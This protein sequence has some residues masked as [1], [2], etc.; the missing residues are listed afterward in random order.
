[1][2][3][4]KSQGK[5]LDSE[6]FSLFAGK[7]SDLQW[8]MFENRVRDLISDLLLPI[9]QRQMDVMTKFTD[10]T[11]DFEVQRRKLDEHDFSMSKVQRQ[12]GTF[13]EVKKDI[14]KFKSDIKAQI[15]TMKNEMHSNFGRLS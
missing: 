2:A 14:E 4:L 11:V 5:E 1:M 10:Q 6:V 9:Q 13:E 15:L 3:E 7:A 12:S 8:F